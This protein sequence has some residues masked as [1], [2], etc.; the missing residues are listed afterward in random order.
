MRLHG[1]QSD[2]VSSV[3]F[4]PG[5]PT[6]AAVGLPT[7]QSTPSAAP[8]RGD[9]PQ[10]GNPDGIGPRPVPERGF[11]MVDQRTQICVADHCALPFLLRIH[12]FC[13][14]GCWRSK[15]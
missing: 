5:E 7:A 1:S 3:D 10:G 15:G 14:R 6:R 9:L 12:G 4:A 8:L 13:R 2:N 11:D